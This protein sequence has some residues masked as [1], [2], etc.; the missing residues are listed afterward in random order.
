MIVIIIC[1]KIKIAVCCRVLGYPALLECAKIDKELP[2][3]SRPIFNYSMK[4]V[5]SAFSGIRK[6]DELVR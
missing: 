4:G 5:V 1:E 6:R 2:N 3:P